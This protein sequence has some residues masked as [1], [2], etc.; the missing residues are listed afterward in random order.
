MVAQSPE[1]TR[2]TRSTL[3]LS[4]FGSTAAEGRTRSSFPMRSR[5]LLMKGDIATESRYWNDDRHT[6]RIL[7]GDAYVFQ[8]RNP[9]SELMTCP[10][11]QALS[12]D[13]SQDTKRETSSGEPQR[14]AGSADRT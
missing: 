7:D 1:S 4:S 2:R 11:I 9:P 10:V 14:A 8:R 13:T 5:S 12:S 6:F 3:P